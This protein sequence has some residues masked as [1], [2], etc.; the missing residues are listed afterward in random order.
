[1]TTRIAINGFGRIGRCIT[2]VL[3]DRGG[4]DLQLVAVN[5]L[6]D[7]DTLVHLLRFDSNHGR[8]GR[9]VERTE[10]G[11]SVEGRPVRVLAE[12]D[13]ARLPWGELG[14]DLVLECTG[15]FRTREK[16]AAHLEA[17]ASRVLISAPG[18]ADVDGTFV[19]GVNHEDYDPGRHRVVSNASCT[20]NCLAPVAK[21]LHEHFGIREG[22]M[23]T[24]HAYTNDQRILD[25]PHKDL[26]RA[27]AAGV[28]MI[29]T[30]TGA[31]KAIGLVLPELKGRLDGAAIRV[32][33]PNVSIVS[34]TARVERS[35]TV[36]EVNE[37]LRA[38]AEGPLKGVLGFETEPLVSID[39]NGEPR[40]SVVDAPSTQVM[41]DGTLVHVQ[42][43]YD[44]E[45][46][47]SNRMVD[48]AR[49]LAGRS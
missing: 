4:D 21:V 9:S 32:P 2:R 33:T 19:Y 16:A 45:W 34:L 41:G 35:T 37:A 10:D 47:F 13:P 27:R 1:M 23:L 7:P 40:S 3:F 30:T 5:D 8:W 12:P 22:H 6:T 26:R 25:L 15:R 18:G 24:V 42:A 48:M 17:G 31:A 28:S 14:V 11:F 39:Y 20:T 29:P 38:A 46:G 49:Y 44:N 36:E 43:W